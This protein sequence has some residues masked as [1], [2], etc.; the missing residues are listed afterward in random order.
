MFVEKHP[1]C[2]HVGILHFS[3]FTILFMMEERM[4]KSLFG[5]VVLAVIS[6]A[7]AQNLTLPQPSPRAS[8]MQQVGLA[9]VSVEYGSPAVNGREVWN[10]LVPYGMS[11]GQGFNDGNPFPWRAGANE[12][13]VFAT[14]HDIMVEGKPLK[15]GS[16]GLHM[17]PG[18]KEWIVIFSKNYT[19]WGSFFYKENEDALRVTVKP[20]WKNESRDRLAYG[21][22]E[23][24]DRSSTLH[25]RWEKI[26]IPLK[27]TIDYDNQVMSSIRSELKTLPGFNP[28]ALMQAANMSIQTNSDLKEALAWTDRAINLGGGVPAMLTKASVLEK[29]GNAKESEELRKRAI[30]RATEVELNNY[31]YALLGRQA[32]DQALEIFALNVK[33]NPA[34]WNVYDS[35]AEALAAKGDKKKAV[36]NYKKALSLAPENQK[37]RI[38]QILGGLEK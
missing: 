25:L 31:G 34:S 30:D 28:Q 1:A 2:G 23:T 9:R 4:K 5:L 10:K 21:F 3:Y 36:E 11:P 20:E 17:I 13:T 29:M 6:S 22:D 19:S 33:K 32:V 18:E 27:I 12:N 7:T 24:T 35:Y 26:R 15:A 38:N 8:V 14:T 16:Y 37:P